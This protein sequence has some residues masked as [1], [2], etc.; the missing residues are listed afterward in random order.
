MNRRSLLKS[1]AAIFVAR[2]VVSLAGSAQT[3]LPAAPF[4]TRDFETLGAIAEVVL[5][6][7]LGAGGRKRAVDAFVNWFAKYRPGADM[8]HGYGAS[9]LRA[10]SGPSPI[11]RYPPQFAALDAAAKAGGASSLAAMPIGQR[12]D[13][14]ETFLNQP[15]PVNRMPAQPS[16]A[17]LVADFMGLYFSSEAAWDLCY[18]AEIRRDSCRTLDDS[19]RQP[20]S[21]KGR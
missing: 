9:T 6:S 11:A 15:Q 10:P 4:A 7:S 18:Q 14:I 1:F 2:P 3:T 13:V 19:A 21:I 20:A 17:N 16:G 8:G 12:R 5:P